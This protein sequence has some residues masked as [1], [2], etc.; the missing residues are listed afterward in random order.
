M[1]EQD[2]ELDAWL[3]ERLFGLTVRGPCP[4]G[5][6]RWCAMPEVAKDR[7][8]PRSARPGSYDDGVRVFDMTVPPYSATS[9]GMIKVLEAMRERG[10]PIEIRWR[11]YGGVLVMMGDGLAI[12]DGLAPGAAEWAETLPRAVAL[13]AKAALEAER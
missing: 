9:D 2:W 4:G 8:I 3:A 7:G 1:S 12:G 5:N 6:V 13:A 10:W 11:P